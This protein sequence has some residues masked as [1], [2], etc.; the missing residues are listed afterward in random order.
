MDTMEYRRLVESLDGQIAHAKRDAERKRRKEE[1]QQKLALVDHWMEGLTTRKAEL[2]KY[3]ATPDVDIDGHLEKL[4]AERK[5]IERQLETVD[6]IQLDLTQE[7]LEEL[8]RVIDEATETPY[9]EEHAYAWALIETWALRWRVVVSRLTAEAQANS[10]VIRKSY[11]TLRERIE[12]SS[13]PARF[14]TALDKTKTDDWP[15][16]LT[17][18]QARLGSEE[19]ERKKRE[20]QRAAAAETLAAL[21]NARQA[22]VN[23]PKRDEER[24]LRHAVREAA[25]YEWNRPEVGRAVRS[26]RNL[27]EPEFSFLWSNGKDEEDEAPKGPMSNRDIL[28]R[29]LRRMKSKSII[30]GSHAPADAIWKGFPEDAKARAK[31]ALDVLVSG[32]VVRSKRTGIGVRVSL[33]PKFVARVDAFVAGT[34]TMGAPEVEEWY[35]EKVAKA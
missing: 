13:G 30:G 7:D 6:T 21:E 33:E 17:E 14:I 15:R 35:A 24:R 2:E 12:R 28:S 23:K 22:Y 27:L 29:M 5:E 3:G 8:D 19:E 34:D 1:V 20:A 26:Q 4:R 16:R 9:T 31:D 11:A 18:A 32:G 25:K 10:P